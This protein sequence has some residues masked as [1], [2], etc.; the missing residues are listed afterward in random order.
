MPKARQ[1]ARKR[2]SALLERPSEQA[3]AP[4]ATPS[5]PEQPVAAQPKIMTLD[6]AAATYEGEWALMRVTGSDPETYAP[7]GEF[8]I[9]SPSRRKIDKVLVRARKTE[10]DT[11]FAIIL[12]G[13]QRRSLEEFNALLDK[14]ARGPYVNAL[15]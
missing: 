7:V 1:P 10:P 15:W 4:P 11:E 8:L 12:G 3:S 5:A 9:H 13:T 2:T 14:G 6:E